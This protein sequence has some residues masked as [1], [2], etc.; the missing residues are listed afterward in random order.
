MRVEVAPA[1]L[2]HPLDARGGARG[3]L[4]DLFER[5]LGQRMKPELAVSPAHVHA[6]QTQRVGVWRE[7]QRAVE[8]LDERFRLARG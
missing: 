6:V 2:E 4:C 5:R 1:R 8:A 7:P 3:D